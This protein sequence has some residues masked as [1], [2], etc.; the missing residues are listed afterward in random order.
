MYMTLVSILPF[1]DEC[2]PLL[3]IF[4]K[5]VANEGFSATINATFIT[6][7]LCH[8][9]TYTTYSPSSRSSLRKP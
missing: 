4:D 1:L 7:L 5:D 9:P 3:N 8:I 6:A 2:F